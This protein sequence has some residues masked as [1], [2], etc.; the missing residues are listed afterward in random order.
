MTPEE[1]N[2]L[3][4]ET[5]CQVKEITNGI[6]DSID[7]IRL[8]KGE[9]EQWGCTNRAAI[10]YDPKATK[11]DGSCILVAANENTP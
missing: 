7:K 6:A 11:D 4:S 3:A 8:I 9:V 1:T 5:I 2:I 10:N